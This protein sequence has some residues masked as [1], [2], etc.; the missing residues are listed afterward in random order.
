MKGLLSMTAG[1]SVGEN[2]IGLTP[3][4]WVPEEAGTGVSVVLQD[5]DEQT[6]NEFVP[7]YAMFPFPTEN[8]PQALTSLAGEQSM[9]DGLNSETSTLPGLKLQEAASAD[10]ST[11]AAPSV[12]GD[13]TIMEYAF[14]AEKTGANAAVSSSYPKMGGLASEALPNFVD[15]S[16]RHGE[17]LGEIAPPLEF[18]DMTLTDEPAAIPLTPASSSADAVDI[19]SLS[20]NVL[21]AVSGPPRQVQDGDS[22]VLETSELEMMEGFQ[23]EDPATEV[24]QKDI[25]RPHADTYASSVLGL[26]TASIETGAPAIAIGAGEMILGGTNNVQA[27]LQ[28]TTSFVQELQADF[29]GRFASQVSEVAK[30]LPDGPIEITLSPEEL[31]KVK[32]TFQVSETGAMNVVVAAERPETLELMRRNSDMLL[33]DFQDLGYE[34]SSFEFQQ[35]TQNS[36]QNEQNENSGG[37]AFGM[38]NSEAPL[39]S[40]DLSAPLSTPARLALNSTAGVD[41]RL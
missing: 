28:S 29:S 2:P 13:A 9:S 33:Q 21:A 31:G 5:A 22:A 25:S 35:D 11:L 30:Q 37:N 32:L 39:A 40:S 8:A 41:I 15:T 19:A 26:Q 6:E 7:E 17:D 14:S 3:E 16:A 36:D 10:N 1:L 20:P 27:S 12:L 23:V 4:G 38:N 34:N 24:E 18:G